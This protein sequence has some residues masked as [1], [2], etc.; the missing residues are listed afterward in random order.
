MTVGAHRLV[1]TPLCN[2]WSHIA[3]PYD[4][5]PSHGGSYPLEHETVRSLATWGHTT[6]F[7]AGKRGQCTNGP[8]FSPDSREPLCVLG[9]GVENTQKLGYSVSGCVLVSRY[10]KL[11]GENFQ[12]V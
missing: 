4:Q 2:P 12:E 10:N 1:S 5:T 6:E 8:T 11:E 9:F 7:S 3:L